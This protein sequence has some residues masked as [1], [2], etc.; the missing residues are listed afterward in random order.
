MANIFGTI[1]L[2]A[3]A[4]P[5][6]TKSG[7]EVVIDGEVK[8]AITGKDGEIHGYSVEHVPGSVEG[9]ITVDS[10]LDLRALFDTTDADVQLSFRGFNMTIVISDATFTGNRS[11]STDEGEVPV[12]FDG[13]VTVLRD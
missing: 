8:A 7:F 4:V 2:A 12:K 11:F 9:A 3:N 1:E 5:F 13:K 10:Q 6:Q